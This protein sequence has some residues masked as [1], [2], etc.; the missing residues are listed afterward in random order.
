MISS[1]LY[2]FP[3][4]GKNETATNRKGIEMSMTE[5]LVTLQKEGVNVLLANRHYGKHD[6]WI[7]LERA[8]DGIKLEVGGEGETPDAA[9]ADA[10][11]TYRSIVS[12]GI[13][14]FA[15]PQIE[16]DTA[17]DPE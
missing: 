1:G 11:T 12:E 17:G 8:G 16:H 7:K 6:W 3:N 2:I 10:F 13:K 4:L 15:A 9:V 5:Q 14:A